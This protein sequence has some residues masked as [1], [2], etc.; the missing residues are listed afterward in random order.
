MGMEGL[1]KASE[2]GLCRDRNSILEPGLDL[3]DRIYLSRLPYSYLH[4]P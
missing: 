1:R 4:T 2:Q 3:L